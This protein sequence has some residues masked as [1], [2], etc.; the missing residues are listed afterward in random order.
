VPTG[1][2]EHPPPGP[3]PLRRRRK[4]LIE[5]IF[6]NCLRVY[7]GFEEIK[8]ETVATKG[9]DLR[10]EVRRIRSGASRDRYVD[11]VWLDLMAP[12]RHLCCLCDGQKCSNEK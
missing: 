11:V 7:L 3:P 5:D 9:R 4:I 10:L 2:R 8:L 6:Q 1:M 12:H